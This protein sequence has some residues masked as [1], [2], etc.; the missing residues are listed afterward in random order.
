MY[1][2]VSIYILILIYLI[3]K[4]IDSRF[5]ESIFI[6]DNSKID[7]VKMLDDSR[8]TVCRLEKEKKKLM[9]TLDIKNM[10]DY[11]KEETK[12]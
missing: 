3:N 2:I 8:H 1:L 7:L 11:F 5:K 10:N 12:I 6:T 9:L 4:K